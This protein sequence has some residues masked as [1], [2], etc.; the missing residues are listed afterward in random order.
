MTSSLSKFLASLGVATLALSAAAPVQSQ[1]TPSAPSATHPPTLTGTWQIYPDPFAG[2]ENLFLELEA[3]NGGPKLKEP[4][5]TRWKAQRAKRTAMLKAGTPLA[6]PSS[7]CIPEGMPTIMGAIFPIQ[8]VEA[9]GQVI[10]LGEFLS[11]TRRIFVDTPMPAKDDNPP[12]FYGFSSGKW[13]GDTLVVT[14]KGIRE[15]VQFFEIPHSPD[16]TIT[17]RIRYTAPDILENKITIDDPTMLLEPYTFAF[18][19]KRNDA[20]RM[21]EFHCDAVDPLLQLNPDG[22]MSMKTAEEQ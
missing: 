5:A 22:T 2:D 20:Y 16:M 7:L 10:V 4:Y 11:Q 1:V 12:G 3:P 9:P 21:M 15:D 18:G 6:D 19:Y 17:E 8:I 14:T 13:E